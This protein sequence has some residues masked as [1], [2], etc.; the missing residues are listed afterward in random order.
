MELATTEPLPRSVTGIE[1]MPV[2]F[3]PAAPVG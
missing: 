3:S 2:V 1:R